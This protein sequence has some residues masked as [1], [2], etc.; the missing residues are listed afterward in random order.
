[1][2]C[3]LLQLRLLCQTKHHASFHA[4]F[5]FPWWYV[6]CHIAGENAFVFLCEGICDWLS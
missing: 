4:A 6:A 2:N 3:V 1:M 5:K